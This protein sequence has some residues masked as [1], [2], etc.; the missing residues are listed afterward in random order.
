MPDTTT[1]TSFLAQAIKLG[2]LTSEQAE[3]AKTRSRERRLSATQAVVDLGIL[4]IGDVDRVLHSLRLRG[5]P[6]RGG[7]VLP[8]TIAGY[9]ILDILGHGGMGTVYRA[10]QVA[11]G[12]KVALKVLSPQFAQDAEFVN[13]FLREG[14]SAAAVNHPHV[15]ACHDAGRSDNLL[16]MALELVEGGDVGHL[17]DRQGGRLEERRALEIIR[18]CCLG[19]EA[20]AKAGLIHRDLKPTNIFID[21]EGR[22]KLGDL[23]LA[24]TIA[25]DDRISQSGEVYGTPAFMS[26]EH[27]QGLENLDIRTDIYSLG[28]SLFCMITGRQPFE[29]RSSWDV[30]ARVLND[31]VP[32][33][34]RLRPEI[35]A[36]TNAIIR[37][38]M[39]K[40]RAQRYATPE[41]MRTDIEGVL[42]TG[43]LA[44]ADTQRQFTGGRDLAISWLGR[45]AVVSPRGAVGQNDHHVW[46]QVIKELLAQ[47]PHALI[48]D[49]Q[50]VEW[51]SSEGLALF[52]RLHEMCEKAKVYFGICRLNASTDQA[53]RC[54]HL[55]RLLHLHADLDSALAAAGGR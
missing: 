37:R 7:S 3:A 49:G 35:S 54:V 2:L 53:I 4:S 20:F 51:V 17:M 50:H 43:G 27:A 6:A 9:R 15:V 48:I 44:D 46:M 32:D 16:F 12:R 1:S 40:D 25:Y 14:R 38:A 36:A 5:P 19:L 33:A 55:H 42:A 22:A 39:A 11:L 23:G 47:D 8:K 26:P 31:P 45:D 28:A 30:V 34:S 29:G 52:V 24:R 10:E 18:D 13:R 41:A 21:G